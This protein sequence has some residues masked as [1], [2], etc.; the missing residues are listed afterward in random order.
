VPVGSIEQRVPAYD[1]EYLQETIR[2]SRYRDIHISAE[3]IE[4]PW[5]G[6]NVDRNHSL[7]GL[8]PRLGGFPP[9]LAAW[10]IS[11]FSA[12][13]DH[14]IDPFCGKGTA[15]LEALLAGRNATGND[16]APDAH[17][18]THA[19]TQGVTHEELLAYLDTLKDVRVSRSI[20]ASVPDDVRIFFSDE[21][22]AQIQVLRRYFLEDAVESDRDRDRRRMEVARYALACLA[23]ILHGPSRLNGAAN[24]GFYLSLN[25]SHT[26]SQ[27]PAYVRRYAA[28]HN[29][30]PP[31]KDVLTCLRRKSEMVQRDGV[32]SMKATVFRERAETLELPQRFQLAITSPPYFRSQSYAWDNWLRLW[33]LGY[34]DYREVRQMLIQTDSVPNYTQM[35]RLSCERIAQLTLPGGYIVLVVGDVRTKRKGKLRFLDE[36]DRRQRYL[37][38]DP[39]SPGF[40][41]CV[42]TS[43]TPSLERDIFTELF[44]GDIFSELPQSSA[45]R[46]LAWAYFGKAGH[47]WRGMS[48][49][50][51][52]TVASL[53]E[54]NLGRRPDRGRD[55]WMWFQAYR[56]L[57]RFD[58]DEAIRRLRT[59]SIIAEIRKVCGIA[60][61]RQGSYD[62][63]ERDEIAGDLQSGERDVEDYV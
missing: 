49:S 25:C 34:E 2:K 48:S 62:E 12:P 52:D 39:A 5:T 57:S 15:V 20:A 8:L 24:N 35:M 38:G 51:L 46:Y 54:E 32:P 7:H 6:M 53:M 45:T 3:T 55:I 13:G 42:S 56:R 47:R 60:E 50:D 14:I 29:L 21:T 33:L 26:H 22:L 11:E 30:K 23:G 9:S 27:S 36:D 28:V 10:T 41:P 44:R 43:H 40:V 1:A 18:A 61:T 37:T 58:A 19:K 16:V 63:L 17:L 59:R 31:N 4:A